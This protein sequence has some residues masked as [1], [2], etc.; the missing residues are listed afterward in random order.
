M[1]L[2]NIRDDVCC[3]SCELVTFCSF[4]NE[5]HVRLLEEAPLCR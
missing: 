3:D 2:V 5:S 1:L 4:M